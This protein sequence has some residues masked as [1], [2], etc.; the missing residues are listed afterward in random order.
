MQHQSLFTIVAIV[1]VLSAQLAL[2]VSPAKAATAIEE[3]TV[4]F[5]SSWGWWLY[6]RLAQVLLGAVILGAVGYF[7]AKYA[8]QETI[9]TVFD[10]ENKEALVLGTRFFVA[11]RARA[12]RQKQQQQQQQA[13]PQQQQ[14]G[15][16]P[17]QQPLISSTLPSDAQ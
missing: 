8:K 4:S 2:A 3:D 17:L 16:G 15:T 9:K 12:D 5:I 10:P 13:A 6:D 11:A 1:A 14:H 7:S